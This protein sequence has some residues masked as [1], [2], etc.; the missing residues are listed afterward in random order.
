[1]PL[2]PG[3]WRD[4]G[5]VHRADRRLGGQNDRERHPDR[6]WSPVINSVLQLGRDEGPTIAGACAGH[7]YV[8]AEPT[9][10]WTGTVTP[11]ATLLTPA[12][13]SADSV[14]LFGSHI[15]LAPTWNA[16]KDP[17]IF[18]RP[19]SGW[20]GTIHSAAQLKIAPEQSDG[21]DEPLVASGSEIATLVVAEND[22]SCG[23]LPTCSAAL[24][25]FSEPH[26]GWHGTIAGPST[27]VTITEWQL[28]GIDGRTIMTGGETGLDLYTIQP[29]PP[30]IQQ[31]SISAVGSGKPRLDLT[32]TAGEGAAPIESLTVRLPFGL[33]CAQQ[34]IDRGRGI[35]TSAPTRSRT[36]TGR[37]LSIALR[38]ASDNLTM[39][40]RA[41]GLVAQSALI[42]RIHQID[43]Y[44]SHH[45]RKHAL[46]LTIRITAIDATHHT[47][48][49]TRRIRIT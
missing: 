15:A 32:L 48:T 5:G 23:S 13:W 45:P 6:A 4:R 2:Q 16:A 42:H 41:P 20:S 38:R 43:L 12:N 1:M 9:S 46:T 19:S 25:G 30:A 35:K 39:T 3:H 44:N 24:Y 27:G 14:A 47:T 22:E 18:N 49:L 36:C 7:G 37:A 10:G 26:G 31:S 11:S 21:I 33:R 28:L 8:F 29:G 17:L 40:I 34:P